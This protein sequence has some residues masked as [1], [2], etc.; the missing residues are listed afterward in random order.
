VDARRQQLFGMLEL[1]YRRCG[2]K[3][4]RAGDGTVRANGPGGVTWIGMPILPDDLEEPEFERRLLE[5]SEQRMPHGQL[6]PLELL[7][8]E[9][10]AAELEVRLRRLRLADRGHVAVYSVAA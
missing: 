10:C 1:H 3:V 2:W 9:E 6:C 5:L 4:E 8:A 7:P